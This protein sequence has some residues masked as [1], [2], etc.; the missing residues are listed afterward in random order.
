VE[1]ALLHSDALP[2]PGHR[3]PEPSKY[4][5]DDAVPLPVL[6]VQPCY[7]GLTRQRPCHQGE[8]GR[9]VVAGYGVVP[10]AVALTSQHAIAV[11]GLGG[12]SAKV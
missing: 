11:L 3:C 8:R 6:G 5:E 9:G 2:A 10:G 1:V 4:V 7:G 12:G